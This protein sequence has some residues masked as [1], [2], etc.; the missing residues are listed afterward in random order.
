MEGLTAVV[1]GGAMGGLS[2][3]IAL[4]EA[5]FEVD[6]YERAPEIL[7]IGAGVC[8]WPNGAKA[9]NALGVGRRIESQSPPLSA[10]HYYGA[11]GER[12][13]SIDLEPLTHSVGQRAFPLARQ[14]LQSTLLERFGS[15]RLH[16]GHECVGVERNGSTVTARFAGGQEA[17]GDLLIG[18]DGVRSVV[19]GS[20]QPDSELRYGYSTWLGMVPG[21]LG[22]NPPDVFG[23]YVGDGK[24]VGMLPVSG[25]RIYFF[26]DAPVPEDYDP[27]RDGA[28]A[29]LGS[30]FAGWA[31][32]V[33]DLIDAVD[34]A[35]PRTPVHDL[36][37]LP[38]YV[39]GNVALVGDAA[40]ASTPT[41]GQGGAL[42]MEDSLVLARYLRT[43]GISVE[44]TLARYD[45]ERRARAQ[46]VVAA[47][48]RRSEVMCGV[49]PGEAEQWYRELRTGGEDFIATLTQVALA[50][51][52][53]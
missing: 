28:R 11:D 2:A 27:P 36:E 46:P 31:R 38:S 48:R 12:I 47:A 34:D 52:F 41:L 35:M 19:R 26:F 50:G 25:D 40:H 32:P 51:P 44:D 53:H 5:G 9:L 18:A 49:V 14:D 8:M 29:L 6:V 3:G 24:R 22:V 15:E 17:G 4:R 23:M 7:P 45:V 43:C 10:V 21:A 30:L 39:A 33:L 20:V 42:A 1:I 16:L 37:P 13:S